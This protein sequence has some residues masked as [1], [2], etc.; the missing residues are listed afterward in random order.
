MLKN[1]CLYRLHRHP[2]TDERNWQVVIPAE[3]LR[4]MHEGTF[5]GH[6]GEE[7]TLNRLKERYYGPG[8][9]SDVQHWCADC[10]ARKS[11]SPR[12]RA[13]L[14]SIKVGEPLQLVAID[15]LGTFPCSKRGNSYILVA[16][17]GGGE[18]I[19]H[20]GWRLMRSRTKKQSLWPEYCPKIFFCRFSPPQ[21]LHS[22]QGVESPIIAETCRHRK[23]P[24][25]P[26]SPIRGRIGREI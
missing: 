2:I 12:N 15:I 23:I 5:G 7:K 9:Y 26:L 16:G 4:D 3:V 8:H 19:L 6:L 22:D 14:T 17:G 21:Q 11:P 1:N 18:T 20:V 13:C 10:A 25:N 24:H